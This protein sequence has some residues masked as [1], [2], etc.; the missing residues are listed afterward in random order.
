[1]TFLHNRLPVVI[2][3]IAF[4]PLSRIF[5]FPQYLPRHEQGQG[6]EGVGEVGGLEEMIKSR[7]P[8]RPDS[9]L[10]HFVE[11]C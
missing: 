2:L 11:F 10:T 3:G 4:S 5:L 6:G 1:M 8:N 7:Q 9:L